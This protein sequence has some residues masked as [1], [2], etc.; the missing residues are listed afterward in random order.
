M[1]GQ[2]RNNVQLKFQSD[3]NYYDL[4]KKTIIQENV[5]E[6]KDTSFQ[7]GRQPKPRP[8]IITNKQKSYNSQSNHIQNT[9]PRTKKQESQRL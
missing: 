5:L 4:N 7:I 9:R 2:S 8:I 3:V 6:L 1:W